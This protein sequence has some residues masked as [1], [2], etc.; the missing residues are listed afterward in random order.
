MTAVLVAGTSHSKLTGFN[1][2]ASSRHEQVNFTH[3]PLHLQFIAAHESTLHSHTP[4]NVYH[5][6]LELTSHPD[7]RFV[8]Q[9][10]HNLQY[11]CTIGYYRPQLSHRSSNLLSAF[12]QPSVLDTTLASECSAGCILGPFQS[13]PLTCIAQAWG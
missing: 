9:L 11:G 13:P 5:L 12:Q 4:V 8:K 10:I 3:L 2:T 6:H 1:Y 7:H